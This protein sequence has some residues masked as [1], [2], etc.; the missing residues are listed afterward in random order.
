MQQ[1]TCKACSCADL[2]HFDS[3]YFQSVHESH[4]SEQVV[5]ERQ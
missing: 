5:E 1:H 4:F 2:Q 3:L